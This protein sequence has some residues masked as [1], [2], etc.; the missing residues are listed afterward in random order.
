MVVC[1]LPGSRYQ[2]ELCLHSEDFGAV[3]VFASNE[4][5]TPVTPLPR[6]TLEIE[7]CP[8]TTKLLSS[9]V[10]LTGLKRELKQPDP[11]DK[12]SRVESTLEVTLILE[13][14]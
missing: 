9:L 12:P 10:E 11:P 13:K 5:E 14:E 2:A 3:S 6:L 8:E 1:S 7:D 4:V